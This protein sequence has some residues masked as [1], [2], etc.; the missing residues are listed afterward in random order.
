[1]TPNAK[2]PAFLELLQWTL[3]SGQKECSALGYAPLPR[4]IVTREL[5]LLTNLK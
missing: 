2:K 1:M 4:E 5:Q 3:T